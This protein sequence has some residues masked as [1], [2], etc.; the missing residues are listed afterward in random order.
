[1]KRPLGVKVIAV[2]LLLYGLVGTVLGLFVLVVSALHYAG[3]APPELVIVI[4]G[5]SFFDVFMVAAQTALG[6]FAVV[7]GIG[8]LRLRPWAWLMAMLLLGCELAIQL[9]NY[10]QGRPAYLLMLLTALLVFYLNR[11]SI[12]EVFG[13][14]PQAPAVPTSIHLEPASSAN[15]P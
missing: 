7:S 6:V 9:I 4:T 15:E 1:M 2:L 14:E 3:K 8:M 10:F 5:W 12:R 11:H 13:I